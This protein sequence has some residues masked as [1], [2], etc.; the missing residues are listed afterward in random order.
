MTLSTHTPGPWHITERAGLEPLIRE[1]KGYA[2]ALAVIPCNTGAKH[3]TEHYK[4]NAAL[5]ASA[6]ELLAATQSLLKMVRPNAPFV[7]GGLRMVK[8]I[9]ALI[10]KATGQAVQ[11]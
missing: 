4:A 5:L 3:V 7:V 8:E 2:V 10:A 6:P 9:E 11:S 1:P